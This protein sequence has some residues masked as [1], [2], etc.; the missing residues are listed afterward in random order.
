MS[1]TMP[2][3]PKIKYPSGGPRAVFLWHSS[4]MKKKLPLE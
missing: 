1:S 4:L 2:Y 3:Q